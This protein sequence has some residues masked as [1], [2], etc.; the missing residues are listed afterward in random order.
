VGFSYAAR[1][2]VEVAVVGAGGL[3]LQP[4]LAACGY[5]VRETGGAA[6]GGPDGPE[7]VYRPGYRRAALTVAG[8]LP[9]PSLAVARDPAAPAAVT[10]SV[11]NE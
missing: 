1:R 3:R 10:V 11:A 4:W 6:A 2:T 9:R 5:Q 8:D 7:V